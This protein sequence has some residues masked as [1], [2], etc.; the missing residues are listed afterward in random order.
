MVGMILATRRAPLRGE[1]CNLEE[2]VPEAAQVGPSSDHIYHI[3]PP[4]GGGNR[5][6]DDPSGLPKSNKAMERLEKQVTGALQSMSKEHIAEVL[7]LVDLNVLR[8]D[9]D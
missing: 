7:L 6:T 4:M 5:G 2:T 1:V 3:L 9:I 8:S